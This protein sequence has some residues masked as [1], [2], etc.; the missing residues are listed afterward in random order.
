MDRRAFLLTPALAAAQSAPPAA[1]PTSAGHFTPAALPE[2]ARVPDAV[3]AFRGA[4]RLALAPTATQWKSRDVVVTTEPHPG[5]EL[6]IHVAAPG[7][8]IDWIG[9]RWK[10]AFP[11]SYR[12]LGDDWE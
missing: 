8:A 7:G 9:L 10:G 3:A 12:F 2:L 5:S 1:E 4:E 6:A 11:A